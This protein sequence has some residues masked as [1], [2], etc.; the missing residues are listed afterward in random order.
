MSWSRINTKGVKKPIGW[1]YHKLFCEFGFKLRN[2]TSFGWKMYHHH[3]N[4][5]CRDYRINL[6]GER[7]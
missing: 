3:L 4:R 6:Y 5:M 7:I 1:W 2:K